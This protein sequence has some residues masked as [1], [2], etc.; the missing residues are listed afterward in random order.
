VGVIPFEETYGDGKAVAEAVGP[1]NPVA[2]LANNGVLIA[3]RTV[4]DAFDR[5]E[6]L[7]STAA[8]IIRAR[9][10]GPVRPMADVVIRDL[11]EAFPSV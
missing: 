1:R 11:L 2:L 10:L 7:E 3:G 9:A 5:L 6:V 4:L 8:A